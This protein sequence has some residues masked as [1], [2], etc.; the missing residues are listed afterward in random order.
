MP[1]TVSLPVSPFLDILHVYKKN[2]AG[3]TIHFLFVK[4]YLHPAATGVCSY[5]SL[6]VMEVAALRS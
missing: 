1:V 5:K 6:E 2:M 4:D 3:G